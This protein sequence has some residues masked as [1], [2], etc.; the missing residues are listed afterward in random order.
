MS[1]IACLLFWSLACALYAPA[2][3]CGAAARAAS[4]CRFLSTV[5]GEDV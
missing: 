5:Y 4:W 1:R 2:L 3:F